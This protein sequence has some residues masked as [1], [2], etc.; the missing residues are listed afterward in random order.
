MK[1]SGKLGRASL[2]RCL[3]SFVVGV[4]ASMLLSSCRAANDSASP[5]G[6]F[7]ATEVA[8]FTA[9][10]SA[11]TADRMHQGNQVV[12]ALQEAMKRP[13][14]KGRITQEQIRR[15]LGEPSQTR[16]EGNQ[17]RLLYRVS[18]KGGAEKLLALVW[19]NDVFLITE[20]AWTVE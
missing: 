1:M 20:P 12:S 15:L 10:K 8:A 9:F 17:T 7:T 18:R 4:V 3:M 6:V 5:D 13:G 14:T 16:V 2:S 19:V 11:D